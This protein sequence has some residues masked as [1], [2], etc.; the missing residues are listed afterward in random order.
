MQKSINEMRILQMFEAGHTKQ[1]IATDCKVC[2]R[3]VYDVIN[4]NG[5]SFKQDRKIKMT[6]K[7]KE[8]YELIRL[9]AREALKHPV[10]IKKWRERKRCADLKAE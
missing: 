10:V 5:L 4:R 3:T 9:L 6:E 2:E 8:E 1:E 7:E